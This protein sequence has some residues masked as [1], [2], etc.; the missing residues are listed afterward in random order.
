MTQPSD[1]LNKMRLGS[2]QISSL[3]SRLNVQLFILGACASL[4]FGLASCSQSAS[5]NSGS[6]TVLGQFS[7]EDAAKF[8]ASVAPFEKAQGIDVIYESADNFTS[9]LRMRI[10]SFNAPD[11]ALL[12]QP[13]LMADLARENLLVPLTDVMETQALRASYSD[14][15]LDLGTVDK[16]L[17]GLW[18]RVSVK[19]LVWYRPTAFED[20][21]YDIPQTWAELAALSDRIVADGG[22]PWCIGLESG[23]ASGWPGTDWVEDILLRTAGPETYSQWISHQLPFDSPQI[24]TAFNEFAKVLRKPKYVAGGAAKTATTFYGD[25]ALGILGDR[26]KCYL[27]RQGNFIESFFPPDAQPRV[28]Y[29]VFP[30]PG[31]EDTFGTPMLVAGD[32]VVLLNKT[33][34]AAA[35]MNY[36]ATPE[37]PKIWAKLGGFISPHQ[38]V[39]ATA[40]AN[41]VTQNIVQILADA[42][43][44]RFDAS[45]MMP[46]AV[47]T[48]TFWS[49]ML[50]FAQGK[51]AAA[52]TKEIDESWP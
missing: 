1:L 29:D 45:D 17:Y 6:V 43:T 38:Q 32:A 10:S 46:G 11:L 23:A 4:L 26:P 19:S 49:G 35:L 33:P 48:G 44:I 41:L 21:G 24:V 28:D 20:K 30:L 14:D 52:V 50:E 13:G 51:S 40:Y 22:T 12:P 42:D 34:E 47:G 37:P 27:H 2:L 39:P 7:P 18:Y 8:E 9:L 3:F 36:L 15:W 16:V 25:A 31:I 5:T